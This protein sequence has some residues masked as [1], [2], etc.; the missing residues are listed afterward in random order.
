MQSCTLFG[1]EGVQ[2]G[3]TVLLRG[4]ME[5]R[6]LLYMGGGRNQI[7]EDFALRNYWTAPNYEE[8]NNIPSAV[9]IKTF[10]RVFRIVG[11]QAS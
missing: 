2:A 8:L 4:Q 5:G 9:R 6:R 7:F 3:I 10:Q 11:V 1:S